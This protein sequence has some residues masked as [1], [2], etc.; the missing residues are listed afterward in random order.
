MSSNE[1]H[2]KV[3]MNIATGANFVKTGPDHMTI[4]DL[5]RVGVVE[6]HTYHARGSRGE[7]RDYVFENTSRMRLQME[8]AWFAPG[9]CHHDCVYGG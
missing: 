9:E 1:Y 6:R 8:G 2:L 3:W 4:N 7:D 5:E